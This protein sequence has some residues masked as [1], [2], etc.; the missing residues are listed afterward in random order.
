M[1]KFFAKPSKLIVLLLAFTLVFAAGCQAI[2]NLDFN[3]V[4]KNSLKVT[5]SEGKQSVELKLLLD[6]AAYEGSSK[7][8]LAL[9][10]LVS[11]LKL[12]LD[13]VKAQDNSHVSFDGSLILGDATSIKF[14]LKMSDKLA[15]MELE[16][17]KQPFVLDLT[18]EGLL[19]LTGMS[20]LTSLT[21]AVDAADAPKMDQA[22]L[23]ELG[24]Q[25]IDTVGSYVIQNLPNPERI[26][27]KPVTES[28]YGTST[29]LMHVHIDLSGAEI[30]AW[31][32]KYV[33]AL[34]ADRAGLDK[35]VAGVFEILKTNPDVWAAA[36]TINPFEDGGIDAPDQAQVLKETTDGIA[37][38]LTELQGELKQL[39]EDDQE[40][41]DAL[42]KALT[43]KADVYVDSKLD[44][45]KQAYELTYVPVVELEYGVLPFKGLTIKVESESWNV[46]GAVKAEA[47]VAP[48]K[49]VPIEKLLN[50]QG[51]QALKQF[52][53][54]STIYDLLKNKLHINKQNITWNS[55][56]YYNPVIV[57]ASN[58]TIIPLRD[59]VEQL[60][61][62]LTYDKNTKSLKVFDEATNTT[63]LLKNG[64]DAAIVNGKNVKWS[65]PVTVIDGVTYVPA[66]NLATTLK[67]KIGW[68]VISDEMRIFTL[69]REV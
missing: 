58:I 69:D 18:S 38:L 35:M 56:Q 40:M 59:T 26:E 2:S 14:S 9:M 51:Y 53:E 12:Q 61:G 65:F 13:N 33:D 6:E 1:R 39:A 66:R 42:S 5:S 37:L 30:W 8:E 16:G 60:G 62:V 44:I 28:I 3:T 4:L 27:V 57:T 25:M 11:N 19:G 22:A 68:T 29:S 47:P 55:Y 46:N 36:G 67:A 21:G 50:M 24:H 49:A 48:E 10:K 54:N 41:I 7:E 45:R 43:I 32:K 34:I 15:V 23:T 52:N 20:D 17:A 63:I 64:S 31:V